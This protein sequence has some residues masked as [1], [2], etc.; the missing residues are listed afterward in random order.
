LLANVYTFGTWPGAPRMVNVPCQLRAAEHITSGFGEP[1]GN[2]QAA[3]PAVLFPTLT[4]VRDQFCAPINNPDDVE[5]PAGSGRIY[6][7]VN[8]DDVAKGFTNEYR[9][10]YVGKRITWPHIIP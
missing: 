5:V 2:S 3:L 4:D 10:A 7:V 8:V 1:L 9:I 6:A